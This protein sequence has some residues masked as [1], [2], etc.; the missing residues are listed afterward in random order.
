MTTQQFD[1]QIS[2]LGFEVPGSEPW[3]KSTRNYPEGF[4]SGK[5]LEIERKIN[6]Q[7]IKENG[8]M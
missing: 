6:Q 5:Q 4:I 2:D 3:L 8:G 1:Q 7:I